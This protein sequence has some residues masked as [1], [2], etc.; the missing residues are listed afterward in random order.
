MNLKLIVLSLC[1]LASIN[2]AKGQT[3][4]RNQI[5]FSVSDGL[6]LST[7]ISWEQEYPMR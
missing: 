6:T 7:V 5:R 2:L 4:N 1:V 3:D